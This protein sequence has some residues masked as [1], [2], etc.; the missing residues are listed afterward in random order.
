MSHN[1]EQFRKSAKTRSWDK[2]HQ[3]RA[4]EVEHEQIAAGQKPKKHEPTSVAQDV[5]A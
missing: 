3:A 4:I 1:E 2:R 5:K